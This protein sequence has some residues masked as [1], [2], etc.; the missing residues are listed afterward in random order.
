[1]YIPHTKDDQEYL[2]KTLGIKTEEELYKNVKLSSSLFPNN[3]VSKYGLSEYELS[4][5]IRDVASKNKTYK[6]ENIYLGA[7]VYSHY[8]P[9]AVEHIVSRQ[10]F[11]TAYT[12]Y[13]PEVSQGT[14]RA[15]FEFQ[16]AISEL[17]VQP[18]VNASMYDGATASAE[19]ILMAYK[20]YRER[21]KTV[22]VAGTLHP[23][24]KSVIE[25]YTLPYGIKV[26]YT[27]DIE[28]QTRLDNLETIMSD[29]VFAVLIQYPN[30][31]GN[32]EEELR[33]ILD[34]LKQRE[35]KTISVTID[36]T[37]L[38]LITPPGDL[39]FDISVLEIQSFGN[40]MAYGGPHAGVIATTKELLRSLPGRIVGKTV[41]KDGNDAFVLTLSTREQHI[42]REKATSNICTNQSLVA[43]RTVVYLSLMGYNGL[44]SVAESSY[45]N[46]H[47][48]Y[49][50]LKKHN[51]TKYGS[52]TFYN[53]FLLKT[54]NAKFIANALADKGY[55]AGLPLDK[56]LLITTTELNTKVSLDNFAKLLIE[57]L[58][59][60]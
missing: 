59:E 5:H 54:K 6:P 2:Y 29:D 1:M 36:G 48:L 8:I 3:S 9:E 43:L 17:L 13:Q 46:A 23:E 28:G 33:S 55:L 30:F 51:Y 12:P 7:G 10:E 19:A 14:L 45:K 52:A 40:P 57:L 27:L 24:Y 49:N 37:V 32:L 39:G 26:I 20:K 38:P 56:G 11:Y 53:E 50:L 58:K 22:I 42:R 25:N 16:T 60:A 15:I 35:L 44:K 21:K 31:F 47:Y 41:D 18:V 34:F 4:K